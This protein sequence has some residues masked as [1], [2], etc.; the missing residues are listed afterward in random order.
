M[1]SIFP[2]WFIFHTIDSLVYFEKLP[3]I[4]IIQF[5]NLTYY[6]KY[7][8]EFISS[9]VVDGIPLGVMIFYIRIM[10]PMKEHSEV[11]RNFIEEVAI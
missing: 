6:Q 3:D 1:L 11:D 5:D 8:K 2:K 7:L 4:R 9:A 10:Y